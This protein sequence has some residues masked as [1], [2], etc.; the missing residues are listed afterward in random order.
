MYFDRSSD[1]DPGRKTVNLII[2]QGNT[3][4]GPVVLLMDLYITPADT[5]YS[6]IA[7]ENGILG[8]KSPCG[9]CLADFVQCLLV[10]LTFPKGAF[11]IFF[12]WEVKAEKTMKGRIIRYP[13]NGKNP[14]RGL[15]VTSAPVGISTITTDGNIREAE[16]FLV[17]LH[18]LQCKRFGVYDNLNGILATTH[19]GAQQNQYD[20]NR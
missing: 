9:K 14:Q 1:L 13:G 5:V 15:T 19:R 12:G 8:W 2:G 10:H 16:C 20:R 3:A 11:R 18:N 17:T 7:A 4:I 6:K